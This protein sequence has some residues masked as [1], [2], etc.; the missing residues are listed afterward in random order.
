MCWYLRFVVH[1]LDFF[2]CWQPYFL[3]S[4]RLVLFSC[5][6]LRLCLGG[7]AVFFSLS[8]INTVS[9]AHL[10]LL[11]LR[12]PII[13]PGRIF[14]TLRIVSL[15]RL[16][17]SGEKTHPFYFCVTLVH[18]FFTYTDGLRRYTILWKL[19]MID[20]KLNSV[21]SLRQTNFQGINMTVWENL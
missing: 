11:R 6:P 12:T 20:S 1:I 21:G 15:Y 7:S 19:G 10:I 13:N 2:C 5:F 18:F 4:F 3:L 17:Q 9:S 14:S 8:A 16:N